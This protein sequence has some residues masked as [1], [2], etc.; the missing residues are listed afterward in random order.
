[1]P[2][3]RPTAPTSLRE[4]CGNDGVQKL[5]TD[6][7][8][9]V[10]AYTDAT[11]A[12]CDSPAVSVPAAANTPPFYTARFL[13]SPGDAGKANTLALDAQ[14]HLLVVTPAAPKTAAE[15]AK[16]MESPAPLSG[17]PA[18]LKYGYFQP[19]GLPLVQDYWLDAQGNTH[20]R[21]DLTP[22]PKGTHLERAGCGDASAGNVLFRF[23]HFAT[24][25]GADQHMRLAI[26]LGGSLDSIRDYYRMRGL[27]SENYEGGTWDDLKNALSQG[28]GVVTSMTTSG[29]VHTMAVTGMFSD[30][31]GNEFIQFCDTTNNISIVPRADF[32]SAWRELK[33]AGLRGWATGISCHYT[34]VGKP[35]SNLPSGGTFL[36]RMTAAPARA[37]L[38]GFDN[39][40]IGAF[41]YFPEGQILAGSTRVVAGLIEAIPQIGPAAVVLGFDPVIRLA[42][43]GMTYAD[44]IIDDPKRNFL[45]KG[46][47]YLLKGIA[48][49]FRDVF[50]LTR[51]VAE[52]VGALIALLSQWLLTRWLDR[53]ADWLHAPQD[54]IN[55]LRQ[56]DP[57][58]STRQKLYWQQLVATPVYPGKIYL[59]RE[60]LRTSGPVQR[61]M[62]LR[63]FA[64]LVNDSGQRDA[65]A[66]ASLIDSLGAERLN[67][68]F[69]GTSEAKAWAAMRAPVTKAPVAAPLIL[70]VLTSPS[71]QFANL[72]NAPGNLG[73]VP[74]APLP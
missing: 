52:G 29:A 31:V 71:R 9:K 26:G 61:Q 51:L 63:V 35:G 55:N 28:F 45:A 47:A 58:G 44:S 67:R 38:N 20:D 37:M 70:P 68:V 73:A 41:G 2:G 50:A 46:G 54:T 48:W 72:I 7:G 69:A 8:Q 1:M 19:N 39:L 18:R 25:E 17:V 27:E 10:T 33:L 64:S 42:S 60:L 30:L 62:L 12:T 57:N 22:A 6:G 4:Y 66:I 53:F 3:I 24:E 74:A 43:A 5:T 59:V 11:P 49:I 32:E 56:A 15:M 34:L 65:S 40:T 23:G 36:G 21:D 16:T 13:T 14:D